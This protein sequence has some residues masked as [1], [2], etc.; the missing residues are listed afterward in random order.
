MSRPISKRWLMVPALVLAV[1][2]SACGGGEEQILLNKYFMASK[3]SDNMTLSNIATVAFDPKVDGQM[4]S[5][6]VLSISEPAVAPL[7]IKARAQELKAASDEEKAFSEKKKEYQ[8]ANADG[9]DRVLK[10]E[11]KNQPLRGKDAEIQKEWTKWREETA[12]HAKK[13]S[14]IR[15]QVAAEQPIVEISC[16]DQ[17]NPID[18]TAYEGESTTK[19]VTIEGK[20]KTDAGV[21]TKKYVFTLQR[22]TLQ[23]VNGRELVGR[24]VVAGR[25]D[26]E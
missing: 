14:E 19:D 25:K 23:G 12:A 20:V 15:K 9:I 26:A 22:I 3:V 2:A 21:A 5:F 6:K 11:A 1:V 16:Q 4:Q 17:R 13:V 18:T 7:T 24:W 10:A 8:D